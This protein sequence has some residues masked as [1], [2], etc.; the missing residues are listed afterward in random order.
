M[1]NEPKITDLADR[2]KIVF[3]GTVQRL[4]AS[5]VATH[6]VTSHTIVAFINRVLSAPAAVGDLQGQRITVELTSS[7]GVAARQ[8]AVF[9]ANALVYA[10]SLVVEEAGHVV[11]PGDSAARQALIAEIVDAIHRRPDRQVR[12]RLATADVVVTGKVIAVRTPPR[13]PNKPLSE[14]DPEWREAVI[15]VQAVES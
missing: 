3:I 4:G 5:T 8:R 1:A 11:L 10:D 6:S 15:D 13:V 2:T 14:H 7:P 9:F 12:S